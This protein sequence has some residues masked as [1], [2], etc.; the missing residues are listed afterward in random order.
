M[1]ESAAY[2]AM[3][4]YLYA[5]KPRGGRLGIDRMRPLAGALG[6]PERKV[7]TIHIAGTNGKGSVAAMVEGILRAAGWRVGLYTSPHLVHLGERVQVNRERLTE[8]EILAFMRELTP[9][10]ERIEAE[11]GG[12]L[13][14]SFFELMTAMA[15]LQFTRKACDIAVIEVGLGGEFDATNLVD[16]AVTTITSIGL[17]HCEWLGERIED[18]A[19][20]KAG[21]VKAGRPLVLGRVPAEAE[22]V[23]RA[24]AE[25]R[26]AP[27][28][29]V[30]EVY[31]EDP[32]EFPTT[33]LRGF[34]QRVNAATATLVAKALPPVWKISPGAIERG[35][36]SVKWPGRWERL[37]VGG[38]TVVL[39]ASHNPEGA[40]TLE[41]NLA[42]LAAETGRAPI[43]VVGVLGRERAEPLMAAIARQAKAIHLVV[44]QQPRAT[45]QAVLE[46]LI[47]QGFCG[48]VVSDEIE[49][50]FPGGD[51]CNVGGAGDVV[52]VTGS[53]YLVG[54]AIARLR[55]EA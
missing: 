3:E 9:L 54:E 23:I 50:I 19:R 22:R 48:E 17:D 13:R 18:I 1:D 40:A 44:P 55:G 34:Y 46:K 52:V 29:T 32:T 6:H 47:P 4:E 30:A 31:G 21:I 39:D 37:S 16:P 5:L 25:Q 45:P 53:I 11:E 35:L 2:R 14:P 10:A 49:R 8:E 15:F 38:R 20:A 28:R 42:E 12:E 7:P 41:A 33:N 36:A 27:V 26:G 43:V 51:V 24:M